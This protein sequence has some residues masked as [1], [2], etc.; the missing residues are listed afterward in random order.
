MSDPGFWY[1][2]SLISTGLFLLGLI[3][4]IRWRSR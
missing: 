1:G 4:Y 2:L 3:A